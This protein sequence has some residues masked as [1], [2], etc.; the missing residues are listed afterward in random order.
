MQKYL[1]AI[2]NLNSIFKNSCY[3]TLCYKVI[4]ASPL[5][6]GTSFFTL[7]R[8]QKC[9]LVSYLFGLYSIDNRVEC[10]WNNDVEI[11][12]HDVESTGDIVSKAM[13]KDGEKGRCI[14]HE[15]D[16]DMGTAGAKGLL[17]GISGGEAEDSTEDKSVRN[18]NENHI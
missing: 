7:G 1:Q 15:D 14:K 9:D 8:K 6:N 3:V 2:L 17:T 18:S 10:R 16:T 5:H 11:G 4:P 13:G 12:K